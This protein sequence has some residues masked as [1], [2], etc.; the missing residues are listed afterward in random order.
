MKVLLING[1]PNKEGCTYT[2]LKEVEGA[3]NKEGIETEL[4]YIG[5]EV[6]GCKA[7]GACGALGKCVIDDVVNEVAAKLD[8][9]DGIVVGTPTYYA[10][11]S[12]QVRAFLDRLYYSASGKLAGKPGAAIASCRRDGTGEAINSIQKYFGINNQPIVTSCYWNQVHGSNPEQVKQDAEGLQ[13]MRYLGQNMAWLLKSI[14]A[15]KKAGIEY[16]TYE[17]RIYT[18]FIR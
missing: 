12:G 6:Y 10:G 9:I 7:C 5:N 16:P 18:N 3:L 15:G 4:V 17:P 13:T 2:A 14:E 1:S 8:D 11:A